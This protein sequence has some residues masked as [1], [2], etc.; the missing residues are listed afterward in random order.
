MYIYIY[1][2]MISIM[3]RDEQ[4]SE[5][6]KEGWWGDYLTGPW[7]IYASSDSEHCPWYSCAELTR[8]NHEKKNNMS[9]TEL[10]PSAFLFVQSGSY[11]MILWLSCSLLMTFYDINLF[12]SSYLFSFWTSEKHNS[13]L[14]CFSAT[15]QILAWP[16]RL[17]VSCVT[18][19][20][21]WKR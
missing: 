4:I 16:L 7:I 17:T 21:V 14:Q 2:C 1:I 18:P 20:G 8:S 9:W 6:G 10:K 5:D 12:G 13:Q 19:L 11:M 3:S 15:S